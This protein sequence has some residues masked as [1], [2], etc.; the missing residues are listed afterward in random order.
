M[1]RRLT[2]LLACIVCLAGLAIGALFLMRGPDAPVP[3]EVV[4]KLTDDDNVPLA[5]VPV[6]LVF[7]T[8]DWRA[9]EAGLRIV[10]DREG[11]AR[12]TAPAVVA[13]RWSSVNIG[14]TGFSMP[15]RGDHLAVGV[16]LAYVLP[17]RDG[18]E[19]TFHWLYT[20]D[21]IRLPDG[22]CSTDDLDRVYAAGTD[23]RF[24]T[25]VGRNA[26]GPSFT[27][28][29]DGWELSSA[30]YRLSDFML[31]RPADEGKPWR[32]RLAIKR[33]PKPVIMP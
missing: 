33:R 11:A 29:V 2:W 30:G 6:R 27:G 22:D 1:K 25:L 23:G 31:S 3:I 4:F 21:I 32:L 19:T 26:A 5:G 12:F 8:S 10:T 7:G 15:F 9:P 24:T 13:R 16:E 28:R 18:G 20:A 17:K 14:F